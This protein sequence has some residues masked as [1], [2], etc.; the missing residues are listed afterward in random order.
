MIAF[1]LVLYSSSEPF[2]FILCENI[3]KEHKLN[4]INNCKDLK[5][6]E[7]TKVK[8]LWIPFDSFEPPSI[9]SF[10]TKIYNY[11]FQLVNESIIIV[12]IK[13]HIIK[14]LLH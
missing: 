10:W 11:I 8:K 3:I 14:Y 4:K 12:T 7:K 9:S 5:M 1:L 13:K 6:Q 2:S